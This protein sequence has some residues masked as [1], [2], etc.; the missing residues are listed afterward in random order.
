MLVCSNSGPACLLLCI[1]SSNRIIFSG[2]R[3]AKIDYEELASCRIVSDRD[4]RDMDSIALLTAI[5]ATR[6]SLMGGTISWA[7]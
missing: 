1:G 7:I 4:S 3:A 2:C 6:L 5:N